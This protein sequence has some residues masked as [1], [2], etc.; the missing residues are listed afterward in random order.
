MAP[1][2]GLL[3]LALAA[4]APSDDGGRRARVAVKVADQVVTVGE[5]EDRLA[6]IPPFQITMFGASRDE[7]VK[8]YVDQVVV[9][10]LVL[11]AGARAT[12]LDQQLPAKQLVQ[13][14]LSTATLR[15]V[16]AEYKSPAAIPA[17]DVARHYEANKARFE[18]PERVNLWRILCK[19]EDEARGVLADAKKDLTIQKY[20]DLSRAH[21]IDQATKLRGGNLGFVAPDGA[22]NEASVKVDP[23]LVRAAAAVKDGD[24]V[25]NPV[26]EGAAW[27]VVW[28]RNTVAAT[29]RTLAEVDA[30]IRTTLFRERTEA[31]EKKL[32]DDLRAKKVRDVD[33]SSLAIVE[34]P[35]FDAG[36]G[37]PRS[38]P[39]R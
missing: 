28:R 4:A 24:L 3:F 25:P 37:V 7:I 36:L 27:A 12:K 22:S 30:Q 39:S 11:G 32:I 20:G 26:P 6:S 34:L 9:R 21:S 23:A 38:T 19:T 1:K 33:P 5:L 16:R 2:L 29:K 18:S 31:A 15:A 10:E 17:E 14:A 8:A 35:P 13:R